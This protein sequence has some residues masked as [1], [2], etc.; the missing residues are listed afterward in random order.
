[1][2]LP[3]RG[4]AQGRGSRSRPAAAQHRVGASSLESWTLSPRTQKGARAPH[5]GWAP[6]PPPYH[7]PLTTRRP[8]GVTHVAAKERASTPAPTLVAMVYRCC[9]K[10]T[11]GVDYLTQVGP[12]PTECP[13][14][15]APWQGQE[16]H[17]E[18][19]AEDG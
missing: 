17:A 16:V 2:G 5:R 13:G 11:Y 1:M 6:G 14:C 8:E 4:D 15:G 10:H 12:F 7:R 9:G 19:Q 18:V 3:H